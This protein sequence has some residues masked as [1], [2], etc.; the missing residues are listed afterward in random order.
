M[1]DSKLLFSNN[2]KIKS[3]NSNLKQIPTKFKHNLVSIQSLPESILGAKSFRKQTHFYTNKNSKEKDKKVNIIENT[4]FEQQKSQG[5]ANQNS[6]N[7][8]TVINI[9]NKIGNNNNS[10]LKSNFI[11]YNQNPSKNNVNNNEAIKENLYNTQKLEE[12]PQQIKINNSN[13]VIMNSINPYFSQS[14]NNSIYNKNKKNTAKKQNEKLMSCLT[15]WISGY[16]GILK[17]YNTTN[18]TANNSI[19]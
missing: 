4:S 7:R 8:K 6:K 14:V 11:M 19:S 16:K 1:N 3:I 17:G 9:K 2:R 13:N 5:K 12:D 15:G 18:N 10:K